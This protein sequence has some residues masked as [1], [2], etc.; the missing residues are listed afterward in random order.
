MA[1]TCGSQHMMIATELKQH[2]KRYAAHARINETAAPGLREDV[3]RNLAIWLFGRWYKIPNAN[4]LHR[5]ICPIESKSR[6]KSRIVCG[7]VKSPVHKAEE[8]IN[9]NR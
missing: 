3:L 4:S 8:K 5:V 2:P 6:V 1:L 9:E 7:K